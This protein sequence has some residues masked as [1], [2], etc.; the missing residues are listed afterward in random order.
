MTKERRW[1]IINGALMAAVA[2]LGAGLI[3]EPFTGS[4]QLLVAF[5]TGTAFGAV[6]GFFW[7]ILYG[8]W[9]DL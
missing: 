6:M 2:G 7:L 3:S 5:A 1:S 9:W 8:K 4:E